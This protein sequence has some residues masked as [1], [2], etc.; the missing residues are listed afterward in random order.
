MKTPQISDAEWEVMD[1]LWEQSP[2]TS[3]EVCERVCGR[4]QWSPRT[5]KTLLARLV[6]KGVI[7]F[8][9]DGNR[10]VYHPL[11]PRSRYVLE[12]AKSFMERVFGGET[13]PMLVHFVRR[14]QLTKEEIDELRRVLDEKEEE[15][16]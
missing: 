14:A 10:Y 9:P 8:T 6:K 13:T 3:A 11:I 12:E 2:S 15:E 5:V 16:K 7:S 1:V 4:M